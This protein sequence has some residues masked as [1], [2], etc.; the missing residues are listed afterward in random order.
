MNAL[1]NDWIVMPSPQTGEG[2]SKAAMMDTVERLGSWRTNAKYRIG[3]AHRL[4]GVSKCYKALAARLPRLHLGL[5]A[6]LERWHG[7]AMD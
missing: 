7:E 6:A 4:T 2:S 1:D 3:E 5:E